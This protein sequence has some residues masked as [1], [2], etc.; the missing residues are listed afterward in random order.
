MMLLKKKIKRLFKVNYNKSAKPCN[1]CMD[2]CKKVDKKINGRRLS[3][4]NNKE[5]IEILKVSFS[6]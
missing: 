2:A 3:N 1:P 5:M 4:V 6:F